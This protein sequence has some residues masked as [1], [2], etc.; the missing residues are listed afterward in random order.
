MVG[1][2]YANGRE[3]EKQLP[4]GMWRL[5]ATDSRQFVIGIGVFSRLEFRFRAQHDTL[6]GV[7]RWS[8]PDNNPLPSVSVI[9]VPNACP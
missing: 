9:A 7:A 2:E 8:D 6:R 3:L 5:P 1:H 4:Y